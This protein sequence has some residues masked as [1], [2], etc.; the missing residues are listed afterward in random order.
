MTK[1]NQ[2]NE[3]GEFSWG[4]NGLD[5]SRQNGTRATVIRKIEAEHGDWLDTADKERIKLKRILMYSLKVTTGVHQ[6]LIKTPNLVSQTT[7]FLSTP[8]LL[9]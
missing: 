6:K 9:D 4:N 7:L 8:W 5:R 3:L 2:W 1:R